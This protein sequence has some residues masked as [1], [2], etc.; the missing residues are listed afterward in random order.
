MHALRNLLAGLLTRLLD[1]LLD[2][3][4]DLLLRTAELRAAELLAAELLAE[5]LQR[6]GTGHHRH[7]CSIRRQKE[8]N[9]RDHAGFFGIN[10]TR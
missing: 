3:L 2:D 5:L 8:A 9:I 10:P 6:W 7:E 4:S 1:G